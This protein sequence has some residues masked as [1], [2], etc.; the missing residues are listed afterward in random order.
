MRGG[1]SICDVEDANLDIIA[2]EV[3]DE[4]GEVVAAPDGFH[5]HDEA[6][7]IGEKIF[8]EGRRRVGVRDVTDQDNVVEE[9][10]E[11]RLALE[12]V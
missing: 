4:H 7:E 12:E 3:L 2:R 6:M 10:D 1:E 8:E 9:E 11:F 5:E